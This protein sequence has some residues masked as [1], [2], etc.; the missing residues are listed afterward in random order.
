MRTR[1]IN[2]WKN[3]NLSNKKIEPRTE[4]KLANYKIAEY[5]IS[6]EKEK[7]AA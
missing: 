1:D 3:V 2:Y 4:E 5:L 7:T 6:E